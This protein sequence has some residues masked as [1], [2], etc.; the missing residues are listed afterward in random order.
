MFR[1]GDKVRI[2]KHINDEHEHPGFVSLMN[3][4]RGKIMTISGRRSNLYKMKEDTNR[5]NWISK[6][7]TKAKKFPGVERIKN[8]MLNMQV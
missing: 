1:V 3:G 2:K 6:W 8:D 7:F 5:Y 4:W